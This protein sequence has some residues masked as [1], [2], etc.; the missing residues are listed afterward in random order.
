MLLPIVDHPVKACQ[1]G[2]LP[3]ETKIVVVQG[4]ASGPA[5]IKR[6][7][8]GRVVLE[9]TLPTA[10]VDPDSGDEVASLDISK[11]RQ[12]G[13]YIVEV[14]GIG[15]S[16][17]FE[18]GRNVYSQPLW[19]AMRSF[20]GQRCGID[21]NLGPQ[22][23]QFHYPACHTADAQYDPSTGTT[24][25]KHVVGGWHDAGDYGRYVVN[26]G[27]ATTTLLWAFEDN[28]KT[29]AKLN[30]NLPDHNPKVPDFLTEI[31]WNLNWMLGMQEPDGG[32][33]H[34]ETTAF[35]A[36]F[37]MPQ[38][39]T[40]RMFLVGTGKAPYKGTAATADFA[41]TFAAASRAFRRY[42]KAYADQCL[43]AAELAW[44]WVEKN[45]NSLFSTNPPTNHTGG[46]TDDDVRDE[47]LWAC[48]E[49]FKATGKKEY[50]DY[51]LA[52][53]KQWS[54]SVSAKDIPGWPAVACYA[55]LTYASS[56]K[57]TTDKAAREAIV[58]EA[59]TA[60]QTL[61]ARTQTNGYLNM[62]SAPEYGWGSNGHLANMSLILEKTARLANKP[63][64]RQAARE[65][66]HYFFGRNTFATSFVTQLGTR[67][68]MHP[69]HRPSGA[70]GVDQPWPGFLVGGPNADGKPLPARQWNDTQG[71]FR[72]NEI[73]INWNAPLVYVLAC[74]AR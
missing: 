2:Y 19:L 29:L 54:P 16:D 21:T 68:A 72:S 4:T 17:P 45:P 61:A 70:D 73:A 25:S 36:G 3:D 57:A 33:W 52:H 41:A 62:L 64:L 40:G 9:V 5:V 43:S 46:Y 6:V 31:R 30:L 74:E 66:L 53:Y 69:H 18:I 12:P 27:V 7:L 13:N 14:P 56:G 55:M 34:K 50:N 58:R 65:S 35:H 20:T 28:A 39:D 71:D 44:K 10:H 51:F 49:L 1:V 42:D 32:V 38:K 67:W 59:V 47:I 11:L 24:G 15:T 23:P 26:A 8:D 60:S 22:F 63:E 48:A 37:V